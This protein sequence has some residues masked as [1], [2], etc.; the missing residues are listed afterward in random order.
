MRMG[1]ECSALLRS[2]DRDVPVGG[3]KAA[4]E[5][6]LNGDEKISGVAALGEGAYAGVTANVELGTFSVPEAADTFI[7]MESMDVAIE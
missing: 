2:G 4:Y 7:R 6:N 1:S 3:G 5:R